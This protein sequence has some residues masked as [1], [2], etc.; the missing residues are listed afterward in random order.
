MIIYQ[1]LYEELKQLLRK[2]EINMEWLEVILENMKKSVK[3]F[4]RKFWWIL[5][6]EWGWE[7]WTLAGFFSFLSLMIGLMF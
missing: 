7:E 4:F 5:K 1:W 6:N 2:R 3:E